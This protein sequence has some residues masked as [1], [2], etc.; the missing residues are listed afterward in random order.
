MSK[1]HKNSFFGGAR[2]TVT[3]MLGQTSSFPVNGQK[4]VVPQIQNLLKHL[5]ASD[6]LQILVSDQPEL[7]KPA[8]IP[9]D[10]SSV[11][12]VRIERS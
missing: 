5:S 10:S 1:L 7:S 9:T 6:R 11:K 2:L 3:V 4:S 12:Y 8:L